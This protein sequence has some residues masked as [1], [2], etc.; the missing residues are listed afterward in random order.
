MYWSEMKAFF[1][2]FLECIIGLF[3]SVWMKNE[4]VGKSSEQTDKKKENKKRNKTTALGLGCTVKVKWEEKRRCK[5][6]WPTRERERG[7]KDVQRG[8][9]QSESK[10]SQQIDRPTRW[11]RP[12]HQHGRRNPRLLTRHR[13]PTRD[14]MRFYR[15]ENQWRE[16]LVPNARNGAVVDAAIRAN[17]S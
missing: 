2:T 5:A 4:N 12:H 8:P 3:R 14:S 9:H 13:R 10:V 17:G 6:T 16:L 1:L 15:V 11:R 7:E